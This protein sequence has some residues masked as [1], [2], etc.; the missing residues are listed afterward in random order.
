[1]NMTATLTAPAGEAGVQP[2]TFPPR[3]A[4]SAQAI[5]CVVKQQYPIDPEVWP[6][7]VDLIS[8]LCGVDLRERSHDIVMGDA[9]AL[10]L[11]AAASENL[12]D[13]LKSKLPTEAD[14][15]LFLG[16][17]SSMLMAI[18]VAEKLAPFEES[19]H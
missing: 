12:R 5:R 10:S 6:E 14:R 11:A 2:L 9:K 19:T 8:H 3:R 4:F 1:M 13:Q 15:D 16:V 17:G 18:D 7:A